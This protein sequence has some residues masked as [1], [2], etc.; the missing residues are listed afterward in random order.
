[1]KQVYFKNIC[2][3][4]LNYVSDAIIIID[5]QGIITYWNSSAEKMFGYSSNEVL[6]KNIY[7]IFLIP[8]EFVKKF[9]DELESLKKQTK[10]EIVKKQFKLPLKHK[11][12]KEIYTEVFF[13]PWIKKN[14]YWIILIIKDIPTYKKLEESISKKL[15][16]LFSLYKTAQELSKSVENFSELAKKIVKLSVENLRISMGLLGCFK[17]KKITFIAQYPENIFDLSSLTK[18]WNTSPYADELISTVIKTETPQKIPNELMDFIDKDIKDCILFP[19]ISHKTIIG[20]LILGSESENFFTEETINY[21]QHFA[22]ISGISLEKAQIF[23]ESNRRLQ[24]IISLRNIDLAIAGNLDIRVVYK[25]AL[26]EIVTQLKVDAAVI[27]IYNP[28][29]RTLQCEA[30]KGFTTREIENIVVPI[31]KS[32]AGEIVRT[33]KIIYI[34]EE[35]YKKEDIRKEIFI[36]EGFVVYYGIPL[37]AKGKLLG[38]LELF[39]RSL[40]EESIEWFDFLE[41][42]AGQ[43]SIAIDNA[44]LV[45]DLKTKHFELLK[46]YDQTIEGWA[47]ALSLKSDETVEH[48][49]RVTE[50]TLK[51]AR[52]MGIK[53]ED[54]MYIRWGA[55]LHDIGKI[56]IPDSILLKPGCLTEEERRIIEM[57]PVYAYK[58]LSPIEYLRKAIEIPYCH[59]ERWDGTGYPRGLKGKEIPLS[60]RI[61]AV[62]DVWDAL[63]SDRPYRKAW[64]K[65]KAIEYIKDQSGKQFD[66][67]VVKHFLEIIQTYQQ[68]QHQG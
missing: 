32:I 67:E 45:E 4:I 8:I 23:E 1:M 17:D 53:D 40:H 46:A 27:L 38:V 14:N 52:R 65:E 63:T 26:Y 36:K 30:Q 49:K 59:H 37:L 16:I 44:I 51:I 10:N 55:L 19:L 3:T 60:A 25:I 22:N 56:G 68:G 31:D 34:P 7:H 43:V 13:I 66:P 54:L 61:F 35:F 2:N 47:L 28:H 15:K 29:T 42:L 24:K 62:V 9:K 64:P 41:T 12:G 48:S 33:R 50:L 5:E 6:K 21:I 39:H 57:H 11:T 20:I 58:M 18:K